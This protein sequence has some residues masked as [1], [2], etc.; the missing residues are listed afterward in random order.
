MITTSLITNLNKIFCRVIDAYWRC[1]IK[2][3][4]YGIQSALINN[5]IVILSAALFIY[6]PASL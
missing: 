5:A 3:V 6:L 4:A 2:M 1:R